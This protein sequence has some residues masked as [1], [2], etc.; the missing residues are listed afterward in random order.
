MSQ[1]LAHHFSLKYLHT[2]LMQAVKAIKQ[3][4]DQPIA[5][6]RMPCLTGRPVGYLY[7]VVG[8]LQYATWLCHMRQFY[9]E[10]RPKPTRTTSESG[11]TVSA[12]HPV[13]LQISP[14]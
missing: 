11:T 14:A 2:I 3:R 12:P 4:Q 1:I 10:F 9:T 8:W 13:P 7:N 6:T 5:M